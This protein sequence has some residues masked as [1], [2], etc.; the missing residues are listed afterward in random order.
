MAAC[1]AFCVWRGV[2]VWCGRGRVV[3]A[4]V[5]G[6]WTLIMRTSSGMEA[7][8]EGKKSKGR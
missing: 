8:L 1:W 4:L 2:G 7:V 6:R 5:D 3:L